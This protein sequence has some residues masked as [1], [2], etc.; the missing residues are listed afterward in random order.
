M[1]TTATTKII[2]VSDTAVEHPRLVRY[3][4]RIERDPGHPTMRIVTVDGCSHRVSLADGEGTLVGNFIGF[5]KM[6]H[7]IFC[8]NK[9]FQGSSREGAR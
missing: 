7:R 6:E 9:P 4:V 8:L 3:E 1:T 2:T 5:A